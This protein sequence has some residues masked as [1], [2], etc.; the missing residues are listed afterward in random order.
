MACSEAP[1]VLAAWS[2]DRLTDK[3]KKKNTPMAEHEPLGLMPRA[4]NKDAVIICVRMC[5]G[6]AVIMPMIVDLFSFLGEE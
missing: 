5:Q 1:R 2:L 4:V 6:C 3:T